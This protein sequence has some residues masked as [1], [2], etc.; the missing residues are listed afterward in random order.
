MNHKL[1]LFLYFSKADTYNKNNNI[2]EKKFHFLI[3]SAINFK[4]GLNLIS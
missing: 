4:L 1:S 2:N 3:R